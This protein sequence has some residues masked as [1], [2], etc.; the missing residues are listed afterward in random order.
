MY[1]T[2]L[3]LLAYLSVWFYWNCFR[4]CYWQLLFTV[5]SVTLMAFS[6]VS[7]Q[8]FQALALLLF[9]R[10]YCYYCNR[11]R[12]HWQLSHGAYPADLNGI[13]SPTTRLTAPQTGK[14][15]PG[16]TRSQ[17]TATERAPCQGGWVSP[18]QLSHPSVAP[19]IV[20]KQKRADVRGGTGTMMLDCEQ[21]S[22]KFIDS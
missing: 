15:L 12:R 19:A 16:V 3:Q 6:S 13:P 21:L 9:G 18:L 10:W 1:S 5:V 4:C 17:K 7:V 8:L 11:R 22:L 14:Q 20:A 2:A